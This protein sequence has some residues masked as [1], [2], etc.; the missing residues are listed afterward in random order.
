MLDNLR[1]KKMLSVLSRNKTSDKNQAESAE[2]SIQSKKEYL[3]AM[4]S[5][6][7]D[8]ETTKML[9][10]KSFSAK[11]VDMADKPIYDHMKKVPLVEQMQMMKDNTDSYNESAHESNK[12]LNETEEEKRKRMLENLFGRKGN[13]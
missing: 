11:N 3:D 2:G 1:K 5:Q 12:I 6:G 4:K 7:A 10:G 9:M 8:K 13:A